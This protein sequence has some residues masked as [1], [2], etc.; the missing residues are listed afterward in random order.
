MIAQHEVEVWMSRFATALQTVQPSTDRPLALEIAALAW[1]TLS[2][3]P[4]EQ[5]VETFLLAVRDVI[6]GRE[7]MPGPPG[8]APLEPD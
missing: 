3:V 1:T 7:C 6:A 4:P 5:A 8:S 2:I